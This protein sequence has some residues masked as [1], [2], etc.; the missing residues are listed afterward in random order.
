[1]NRIR[2][3]IL[4]EM[5][6]KTSCRQEGAA[7]KQETGETHRPEK[8]HANPI[9]DRVAAETRKLGIFAESTRP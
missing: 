9:D 1:M 6:P 3:R 8:A 2:R 7:D 4:A 5:R